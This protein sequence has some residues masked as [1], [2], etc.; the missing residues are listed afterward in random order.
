ML[1]RLHDRK[2]GFS[3]DR[4]ANDGRLTTFYNIARQCVP[5]LCVRHHNCHHRRR[6]HHH[7]RCRLPCHLWVR[8]LRPVES[9]SGRHADKLTTSPHATTDRNALVIP[10]SSNSCCF[11]LW[12]WQKPRMSPQSGVRIIVH[13][14]I[15]TGNPYVCSMDD[16]NIALFW[17]PNQVPLLCKNAVLFVYYSFYCAFCG[18][19]HSFIHSLSHSFIH[20]FCLLNEYHIKQVHV[21]RQDNE[22]DSK[23]LALIAAHKQTQM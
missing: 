16:W 6:L 10:T 11:C 1:R 18:H 14:L 22:Q 7:Y 21:E 2:V 5:E 13:W 4:S 19:F 17:L 8:R 3:V 23:A 15:C 20:A 9:C 12:T